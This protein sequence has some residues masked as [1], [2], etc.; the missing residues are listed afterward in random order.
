MKCPSCAHLE[1]KVIDSRL[2]ANGETTRRR[3][4]CEKCGRRYTTYERVEEAM[5]SVVK[6]DGRREPYDR[7]K[8][9]KGVAR[10]CQKR[11]VAHDALEQ[12]ADRIE[13]DLQELGDHEVSSSAIGE[14]V[15]THLRELDQVAYV[16]FASVYRRFDDIDEFLDELKRLT[17][18]GRAKKEGIPAPP[19]ERMRTA[20]RED[21][22]SPKL[23]P[24]D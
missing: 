14:R 17:E 12:L 6:R 5:P 1:N 4:E 7:L 9:L 2:S 13:R 11:P 8:L 21:E 18:R 22:P 24:D 3:R 10:A 20:Q 15:M 16:R 23:T 19:S